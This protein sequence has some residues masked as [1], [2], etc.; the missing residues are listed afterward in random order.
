VEFDA[1]H[2]ATTAAHAD[3]LPLQG[4]LDNARRS[5]KKR[6]QLHDAYFYRLTMQKKRGYSSIILLSPFIYGI[7]PVSP[8]RLNL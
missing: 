6:E 4:S 8:D 3:I 2:E 5:E 7:S 1:R